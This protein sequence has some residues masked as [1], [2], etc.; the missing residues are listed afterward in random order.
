MKPL[1]PSLTGML[2]QAPRL[3]AALRQLFI[4]GLVGLGLM[5]S[6]PPAAG[7]AAVCAAGPSLDAQIPLLLER[8]EGLF[9][10][11]ADTALPALLA[12]GVK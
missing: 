12:G 2:N 10:I 7:D 4:L 3:K 8:R 5:V 6:A 11:A 1:L 9:V